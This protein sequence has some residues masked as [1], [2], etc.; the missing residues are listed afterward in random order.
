MH[1]TDEDLEG[2]GDNSVNDLVSNYTLCMLN[3]HL[4]QVF[5][6]LKPFREVLTSGGHIFVEEECPIHQTK[7]AL[8][9]VWAKKWRILKA[10]R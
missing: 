2:I 10:M 8:Q 6:A 5:L 1:I 4:G 9:E 7:T 3:A